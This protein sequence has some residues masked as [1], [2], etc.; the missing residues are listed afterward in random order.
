VHRL[1]AV[2]FLGS[3]PPD[4]PQ[5]NHIDGNKQNSDPRNLEW[6]NTQENTAHAIANGLRNGNRG[7]RHHNA[8]LKPADVLEVRRLFDAKVRRSVI[9]AKFGIV[10]KYVREVG[11]RKSWAHL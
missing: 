4:R 10:E 7:E 2:A 3:P 11:A 1:V 5:I 9:A 6:C 8:K